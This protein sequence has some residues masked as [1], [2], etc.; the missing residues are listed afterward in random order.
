[1]TPLQEENADMASK[2]R[3]AYH[4]SAHDSWMAEYMKNPYYS[5]MEKHIPKT[6][7]G[8]GIGTS[9][10][11][12]FSGTSFANESLFACICDAFLQLGKK[13]DVSK[14]RS[15]LANHYS[16]KEFEEPR[17]T[18]M[19][20]DDKLKD[21]QRTKE[22]LQT[23]LTA[24]QLRAGQGVNASRQILEE[25]KRM[26]A[27]LMDLKK[28]MEDTELYRDEL[29]GYMKDADSVDKMRDYIRSSPKFWPVLWA[30][31]TLEEVLRVKF[32]VFSQDEY[33]VKNMD[34]VLQCFPVTAP[35][36]PWNP[37]HYILLSSKEVKTSN[38]RSKQETFQLIAYRDHTIFTFDEIPHDVKL[39]IVNKCIERQS[40]IFYQIEEFRQLKSKYG[41]DED[42]GGL[43]NYEE[44]EGA[45]DLFD[46]ATRLVFHTPSKKEPGK[47]V[48]EIIPLSKVPKYAALKKVKTWRQQLAD[49][50]TQ[51]PFFLDGKKWQSVEHFLLGTRYRK[52][53]PDV[54]HLFSL[55]S[56]V[57]EEEEEEG[58]DEDMVKDKSID[59][60]MS[61]DLDAARKFKGYVPNKKGNAMVQVH[62]DLDFDM[63]K[64]RT[65]ALEAK[66]GTNEDMRQT[67]LFTNNA[68]LLNRKNNHQPSS[69]FADMPLMQVRRDLFSSLSTTTTTTK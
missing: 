60:N 2:I 16:L 57:E 19:A 26:E 7:T 25:S 40:D 58:K 35:T 33:Q 36:K 9:M 45:H 24:N 11:P 56:F 34:D 8:T 63:Q 6:G 65:R 44:W 47:A 1:M 4:A 15:L 50:W 62:P 46:P 20:F 61:T 10:E 41:V 13:T 48:G 49:D 22:R 42:E 28:E 68:L 66:F 43:E 51:T 69:F 5:I 67:L 38:G 53:H 29:V 59:R 37:T 64:E 23:N 18:Y 27:Q 31:Q 14:L 3:K 39:F 52:G 21:L 30:M 55:D 32:I 17:K 54:Y 12:S